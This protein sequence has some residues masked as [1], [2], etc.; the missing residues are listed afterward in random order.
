MSTTIISTPSRSNIHVG[1]YNMKTQR[2]IGIL[3]SGL[4][5][6]LLAGSGSSPG[7]RQALAQAGSRTPSQCEV[8]DSAHAYERTGSLTQH[9]QKEINT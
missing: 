2:L 8:S 3:A 4:G 1:E 6:A 9:Q 7:S 5:L